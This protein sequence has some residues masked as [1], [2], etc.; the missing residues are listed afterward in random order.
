LPISDRLRRL[1]AD[2]IFSVEQVEILMLLRQEP[3]R[4]WTCAEVNDRIKSSV[5]SVAARLADLTQRGLVHDVGGRFRYAPSADKQ[6]A[7]DDLAA[8][9]AN[10]RFTIIDLIFAKSG[11]KLRVFARALHLKGD[12]DG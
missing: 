11:D 12:D 6:A 8:A 2:D 4:L 3:A 7:L 10:R 1:I 9:Y 5:S